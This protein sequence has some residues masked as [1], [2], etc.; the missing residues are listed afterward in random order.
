[1]S[2]SPLRAIRAAWMLLTRIPLPARW[3]FEADDDDMRAAPLWFPLIGAK[4]GVL[5]G[6]VY[7]VL[8]D[9]VGPFTAAALALSIGALLTG[10]L[11]HDGLADVADAFGGGWS[12][13]RRLE[14]M[15]DS[16]IGAYGTLA[17]VAAFVVQ[18]SALAQH[19]RAQGFAI[20]IAAHTLGRGAVV[21]L[22]RLAPRASST[23]LGSSY[24]RGLTVAATVGAALSALVFGA[25]ALGWLVVF[26]AEAAAGAVA[27]MGVLAWR[28]IG[29]MT[30]D[31]L[32]AAEQLAETA[33]LVTGAALV[34]HGSKW[35]SGH[36]PWWH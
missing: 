17:L 26:A 2:S 30:G 11:H 18:T 9:V 20:V 16:R 13:E 27:L 34:R 4:L 24:A 8:F 19:G 12:V 25:L 36:W 10:G 29:G 33:V 35:S 14:I 5:V 32:G 1:M 15:K 21:V 23:G 3:A 22:M 6:G 28:K 7:A 31:V